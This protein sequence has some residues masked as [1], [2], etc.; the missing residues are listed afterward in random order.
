[1]TTPNAP[2]TRHEL[3]RSYNLIV[4]G[5]VETAADDEERAFGGVI[6]AA[7]G[8]L[9]EGMAPHIVRLAWAECGGAPERLSFGDVKTY[10]VPVQPSYVSGLPPDIRDYINSHLD[11]HFYRAQVDLHIFVD[12]QF[13]IGVE[14]KTYAENAM[15][16][17]I[18]VDFRLLKSQHP[19]LICGLLQLESQLGGDY[20]SPLSTP[21]FGS[22]STHTLLSYF[23]EVELH[24]ITL[25]EGERKVDQPIHQAQHFKELNPA[26]LEH[27][28]NRFAG[29]LYPLV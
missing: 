2:A 27:A 20:S 5:I 24:I 8:K 4:G 12:E 7:K 22:P 29:L 15:L 25:L 19:D 21:Q 3:I 10:P 1:M 26:V 11:R 28:I 16:K 14:C 9:V 23:P 17:R 18:L 6:R 13:S